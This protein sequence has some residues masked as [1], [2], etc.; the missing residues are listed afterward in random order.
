MKNNMRNLFLLSALIVQSVAHAGS[1]D[2]VMVPGKVE[3]GWVV[4][5]AVTF[6]PPLEKGDELYVLTDNNKQVMKV[7]LDGAIKI[8]EVGGRF[9]AFSNEVIVSIRRDKKIVSE[10]KAQFDVLELTQSLSENEVTDGGSGCLTK[11]VGQELKMI[12]KSAMSKNDYIKEVKFS[13][14]QG[15][16]I[17]EPSPYASMNPY[18]SIAGDFDPTS[19]ATE[20][21]SIL[22][23]KLVLSKVNDNQWLEKSRE[24]R[25]K[26][27]NWIKA[28]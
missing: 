22:E 27:D 10:T 18:F 8:D 1:I 13:S 5:F 19:I 21:H 6:N 9:K 17:I 12:C 20:V 15:I 3:K 4:P 7:S 23:G 28:N 14:S 24:N 2:R 11:P 26:A 16:V 25:M